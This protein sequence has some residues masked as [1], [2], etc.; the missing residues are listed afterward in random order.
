[1]YIIATLLLLI[2]SAAGG[3][4]GWL[5]CTTPLGITMAVVLGGFFGSVVGGIVF[6]WLYLTA[7]E[8][9]DDDKDKSD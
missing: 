5:Q 7:I 1:M 4:Y 8:D 6:T 9:E 3:L 2:G